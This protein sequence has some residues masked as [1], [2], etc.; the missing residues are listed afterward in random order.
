MARSDL[1]RGL[2]RRPLTRR[3]RF[4]LGG[5]L[6]LGLPLV[7][8]CNS[9][10]GLSDFEKGSCAGGEPCPDGGGRPDQVSP[11]AGDARAD[12]AA[13][14]AK[15]ADPVSW[16]KWPMPNYLE[17]GPG[18]P[19]PSPP[20]V[21]NGDGTVL[22]TVTKLVWSSAVVPGDFTAI[23]AEGKCQTL[24]PSGSWRAP[25]R[26]EL[27]TL[28]DYSLP[29]FVDR[30]KFKDVKNYRVWTTSE[31]RPFV[32]DNP[33]QP[34]WTVSFE[35]GLVEPRAGSDVAKVLCVKAK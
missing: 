34:Y 20:L 26:I 1:R 4:A 12:G 11:D 32:A 30:S 16:A 31:V 14:D 2:G 24:A 23:Q 9:L 33:D 18:L 13:V 15:G 17:A 28:L 5:A 27:V 22:D 10:I 3:A 7:V 25:K 19:L 8:A 21:V 6:A 35:T 29:T